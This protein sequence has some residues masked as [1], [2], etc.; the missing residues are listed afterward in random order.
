MRISKIIFSV[1]AATT[2]FLGISA[3][4]AADMPAYSKA[5][6]L[7]PAPV[8][9]WTGFYVGGN[10]GYS[11]DNTAAAFSGN[12]LTSIFFAANIFPT[13]IGLNT[14]GVLA[15]G[16][17]GYNWQ[18]SP[19]WV[20]GFETDLQWAN[21]KGTASV[22][23]TAIAGADLFTTSVSKQVDWLGTARGR[24][25]F[26]PAPNVL[27]YGTG[28]LAYGERKLS[29][30]TIDISSPCSSEIPCA[31]GAATSTSAGWT[32]GAGVEIAFWNNWSF[33][34]E[35]LHVDLGSLA[36]TAFDTST[37]APPCHPPGVT[38]PSS[39]SF[40][41]SS[42]FRNEIVRIGVNYKFGGPVVAR[43]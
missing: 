30:N 5:P 21:I 20:V 33:K 40:T 36:A 31:S 7:A 26:L 39:C 18:V 22:V 34:A 9:N 8:Y 17:F 28:G 35:Y 16:Q 11:W 4:S 23:P 43:Y 10:V 32:V 24:V 3:A 13:A 29:F 42:T 12:S 1:A 27:V 15:G 41:A 6:V 25:G 38:T 14:N 37:Q 2:A 19:M